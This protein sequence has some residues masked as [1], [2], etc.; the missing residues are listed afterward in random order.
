L[1]LL[2]VKDNEAYST[3]LSNGL[4]HFT[5]LDKTKFYQKKIKSTTLTSEIKK[6]DIQDYIKIDYEGAEYLMLKD[7]KFNQTNKF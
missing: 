4:I 5:H 2:F 1:I 6:F 7:L 3:M